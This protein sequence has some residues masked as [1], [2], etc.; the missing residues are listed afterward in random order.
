MSPGT[1]SK[2]DTGMHDNTKN[3]CFREEKSFSG[4]RSNKKKK[5]KEKK[6]L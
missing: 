5:K 6:F 3:W 1:L 4:H 2:P